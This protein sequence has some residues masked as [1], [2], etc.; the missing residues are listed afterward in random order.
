MRELSTP[1]L[2]ILNGIIV[3]PLIGVI[4]TQ[5]AALLT[6]TLLFATERHNASMVILD[7]TGVPL[8]DTIVARVLLQAAQAI[9]LLGAQTILVG[10]R[11][12]LAQTITGLGVNLD[13]L[14]TRADLQSGLA[15][16][17]QKQSGRRGAAV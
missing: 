15:Y 2:P 4:D 13:G 11:P 7:V 10:L 17:M 8:I 16:A 1:V 6:E 5:R 12:E 9:K 14:V 3:M